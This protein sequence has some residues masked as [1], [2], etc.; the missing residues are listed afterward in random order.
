MRGLSIC[1][2]QQKQKRHS[3]TAIGLKD[4]HPY[5]Q[6]RQIRRTVGTISLSLETRKKI[7]NQLGNILDQNA[8]KTMPPQGLQM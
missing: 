4:V 3:G 8:S 2:C 6:Y 1:V 7:T 5:E